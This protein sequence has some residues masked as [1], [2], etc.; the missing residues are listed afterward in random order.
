MTNNRSNHGGTMF[1]SSD[2]ITS[3]HIS[4]NNSFSIRTASGKGPMARRILRLFASGISHMC[5]YHYI[6]ASCVGI[7][8]SI[9]YDYCAKSNSL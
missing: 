7:A 6:L 4:I 2:V 8:I 9:K 5:S 1:N 3:S